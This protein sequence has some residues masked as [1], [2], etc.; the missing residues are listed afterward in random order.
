M[1]GVIMNTTKVA[2]TMPKTLVSIID[3][4]SK[5][6]GMSRSKLIS[7]IVSERIETEREQYL[8]KAYDH[9]FSDEKIRKEQL[10]STRWLEGLDTEEGQ[11]W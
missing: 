6:K 7:S 2:I 9:V 1:E 11:E 5:E 3:E 4:L 10:E 8:R